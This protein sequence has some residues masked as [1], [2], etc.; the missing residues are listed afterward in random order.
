MKAVESLAPAA[1]PNTRHRVF[2]SAARPRA[3]TGSRSP[4]RERHHLSQCNKNPNP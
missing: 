2:D 3:L 1:K 4:F